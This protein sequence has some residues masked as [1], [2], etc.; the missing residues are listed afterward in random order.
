MCLYIGSSSVDV[1]VHRKWVVFLN[2]P[3]S[4]HVPERRM[5]PNDESRC[6]RCC[7]CLLSVLNG[8]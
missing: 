6:V 7:E 4:A 5:L 8:V 1:P 2:T 3:K